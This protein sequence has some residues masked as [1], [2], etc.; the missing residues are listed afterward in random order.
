MEATS[1][2]QAWEENRFLAWSF[3]KLISRGFAKRPGILL[4]GLSFFINISLLVTRY[5][6]LGDVLAFSIQHWQIYQI[7]YIDFE[8]FRPWFIHH[9]WAE[10]LFYLSPGNTDISH[11][12]PFFL[13]SLICTK[14]RSLSLVMPAN[15]C[16]ISDFLLGFSLELGSYLEFFIKSI[17]QEKYFTLRVLSRKFNFSC[18]C[19]QNNSK[20]ILSFL[21]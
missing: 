4:L 16:S 2:P 13:S 3:S 1:R 14:K 7:W 17:A 6:V 12:S 9:K 15:L 5:A 8:G 21:K 11:F 18:R 10:G 20:K 19:C